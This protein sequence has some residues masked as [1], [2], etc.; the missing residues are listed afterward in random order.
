MGTACHGTKAI[1]GPA[2]PAALAFIVG[3]LLHLPATLAAN[4][5][6]TGL[7]LVE[8]INCAQTTNRFTQ[9]PSGASSVQTILGRQCRVMANTGGPR[10]FAYRIGE[11]KGLVAGRGYVL[12]VD[13]PE[14]SARTMYVVNRGADFIRGVHTGATV[15][16]ALSP[17]Y[18]DN[19]AES[20]Q[21]P[22]SGQYT[23]FE[24]MFF[25]HDRFGEIIVPKG[26][27]SRPLNPADGFWVV[28][29][30]MDS[31]QAPLSNGAAASHIRLYEVSNPAAWYANVNLPPGGLPQ[32][33]LFWREEMADGVIDTWQKGVDS[34]TA[35]YEYKARLMR[36]WGMNTF[37]KDLLEFGHNQGWDSNNP[38]W[39]H[40]H[41]NPQ[42]W[43][44]IIDMLAG[45][46]LNA[47]PYFEYPGS[48]G[49]DPNVAIGL[50]RKC[51]PL[52]GTP[53]AW[54]TEISWSENANIDVTDTEGQN[55]LKQVLDITV[56]QLRNRGVPMVG[57]WLR[58]RHS[59]LPVSFNDANLELFRVQ[60]NGGTAISR[61]LLQNDD[62]LLQRYYAWWLLKRKAFLEIMRDYLREQVPGAV[63]LFTPDASEPGRGLDEPDWKKYMITDTPAT[64]TPR[65]NSADWTIQSLADT[66]SGN[67]HATTLA[68]FK[69][70]WPWSWQE[71]A[72]SMPPA[73]P[74]NFASTDGVMM[75][76][77]F[78]R[79]YTVGNATGLDSFRTASGLAMVRHYSLNENMMKDGSTDILGYFVSDVDRAGPHCMLAEARA[80]ANGDPRYIGYLA[81]ASFSR[82]FPYYVRRFNTAFL[83]LP[84][85]PSTVL[86]GA[87]SD[88]EVVVRRITTPAHGTYY[89]IVNTGL[90]SKG[91]VTITIPAENRAVDA[92]N[93]N[94]IAGNTSITLSFYA[95]ELKAVRVPPLETATLTLQVAP[96]GA[97]TTSPAV[98]SHTVNVGAATAIAATPGAGK[99]FS[100][101]TLVAGNAAIA[102]TGAASTTVTINDTGGATVRANFA[103]APVQTA[104]L[105]LQVAPSGA[106]TTSPA[107]GSHTV[108]VGAATAIA[109]TP[110]AGKVFSS[111]TLVAGNA[112][113]ANTGAASTTVTINDTG[114]ATVRAN[115]A[116][117]EDLERIACG[118]LIVIGKEEV[119]LPR[120]SLKLKAY[121]LYRDPVKLVDGKKAGV[122]I[123]TKVSAKL[124]AEAIEGE[125]TRR[126]RLYDPKLLGV[127][128]KL[129]VKSKSWLEGT[130]P[131]QGDLAIPLRVLSKE[132]PDML[133]RTV[134]L[135]PPSIDGVVVEST[136]IEIAGSQFGVRKPK[137]WF[138]YETADKGIR[139]LGAKVMPPL[140]PYFNAKGKA[141]CM[142]PQTGDSVVVL[143][144]PT[145]LPAG[146][147]GWE[148]ITHVV[149]DNGCG[150]AT[151]E[152]SLAP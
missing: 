12:T 70:N 149:I 29:A 32:R 57:A 30:Q 74:A 151:A 50:K 22:L 26:G 52:Y 89:A 6:F 120:F 104:T 97:G 76:Y 150:L 45:Y 113:I 88:G 39:Y 58:T 33:H 68:T 95:C 65:L 126:I 127:A 142:D 122:K 141:V 137:V 27:G 105:T 41:A 54:Y 53:Q 62:A 99:V 9:H 42:R 130:P 146:L 35:W 71:I 78:N 138:E 121:G 25:L 119:G 131:P 44:N 103:D 69:R 129:G 21:V 96:S 59:H 15:G 111:W 14:D 84:A 23:T 152:I 110:G 18:V 77:T 136:V 43:A 134:H 94:P 49:A 1:L 24:S 55:D 73:D 91:N 34:D 64:W 20:L 135:S 85:L 102:N 108:N 38:S 19:N 4:T 106:G 66:V 133:V 145:K 72:H 75:T 124:P 47:L 107:V 48:I 98:G 125:W 17:L 10:Y 60:A 81:S 8:E 90:G 114:G 2:G 5:L 37:S 3:L 144:R 7:T 46:G 92:T 16:D 36:V 63:V 13:F 123:L 80:M 93:G 11:G 40:S 109:A 56:R 116:D 139:K 140:G 100:S 143:V 31:A 118:S 51:Q 79:A 82:G 83:S 147:A 101:W 86:A 87:A 132:L 61:W 115:F 28:I 112:A 67:V 117:A 128:H 148:A